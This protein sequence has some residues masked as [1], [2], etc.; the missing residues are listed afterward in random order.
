MLKRARRLGLRS[1]LMEIAGGEMHREMA[2]D[3]CVRGT[4][5]DYLP[6]LAVCV[7]AQHK[8]VQGLSVGAA[9]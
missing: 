4:C 7:A 5:A 2:S 6:L 9:G 1:R 8:L 3:A